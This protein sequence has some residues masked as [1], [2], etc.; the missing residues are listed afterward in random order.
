MNRG[1]PD[2]KTNISKIQ[3]WR[4]IQKTKPTQQKNKS[5]KK[6]GRNPK[7]HQETQGD[8]TGTPDQTLHNELTKTKRDTGTK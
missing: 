4:K 5:P 6:G 7:V 8:N 2:G 3:K 1:R